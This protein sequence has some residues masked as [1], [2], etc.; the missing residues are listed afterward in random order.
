MVADTSGHRSSTVDLSRVKPGCEV[1]QNPGPSVTFVTRLRSTEGA[2]PPSSERNPLALQGWIPVQTTFPRAILLVAVL[3]LC[4]EQ[5]AVAEGYQEG[6]EEPQNSW[7]FDR[8]R[9]RAKL[10]RQERT[11]E[12]VRTG[13][14]SEGVMLQTF[15][16]DG[17]AVLFHP[18]PPSSRFDELK[19]A[20]WLWSDNPGVSVSV[21]IRLPNQKNPQ[22]GQTV[23]M[24]VY[25]DTHQ[26][27]GQWQRLEVGLSDRI[28]ADN[29]RRKR[30]EL[31]RLTGTGA[32]NTDDAYVDQITLHFPGRPVTWGL[33]IDDLEINQVVP[34]KA[35]TAQEDRDKPQRRI[36]ISDERILLDGPP[37]FPLFVPWH[38]ESTETLKRS[39]CN[40]VWVPDLNDQKLLNELRSAELGV[41]ATPPR[42]DLEKDSL[43]SAGLLPFTAQT[44]SVLFWMLDM[45]IPESRLAEATAWAEMVRDA[46]RDRA[47]PILAD[48]AGLE[49]QFHRQLDM[50]GATRSIPFTSKTPQIYSKSLEQRRNSALPGRP[51]FTLIPVAP[52]PELVSTRPAGRITPYIEPELIW[53]QA[54]IALA[55][56][57]KG[58]GYLTYDSLESTELG[59]EERRLAI[60]LM[61]HKIRLLEPWLA[62]AKVKQ[63]AR[64]L[65]GNQVAERQSKA[66]QFL[67][68]WDVRPGEPDLSREGLAAQQIQATVLE[69]DQGVLIFANWLEDSGQYQPGWM[70]TNDVRILLPS[71]VVHATELKLTGLRDHT[72]DA[73]P[74]PSGTEIRLKQGFNQSTILLV[75]NDLDAKRSLTERINLVRHFASEAWAKLARAKLTRVQAVHYELLKVAPGVANSERI[76]REAGTLTDRAEKAHADERYSEAEDLAQKA[77]AHLR[78]LQFNHW[79]NA[80]KAE[81]SPASSPYTVCFQT[82]PDHWAM[83][84]RIG[85]KPNESENLLPSGSFEDGDTVVAAG[86][87]HTTDLPEGS[88]IQTAAAVD[89]QPG[90]MSLH[91]RAEEPKT[92]YPL[93][94]IDGS[95]VTIASPPI[96]VSTGQI[97]RIRGRVQIPR[98]LS[99]TMDGLLIY[100]SLVGSAGALRFAGPTTTGKWQDFEYFREVPASCEMQIIL[101]LQGL[102]EALVDDLSVTAIQPVE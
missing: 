46:D 53:M 34:P 11:N 80:V 67:S 95:P 61:N 77:L 18:L 99:A 88:K 72:V 42:P 71:D 5:A 6:F 1:S 50:I 75:S 35:V 40:V 84:Q 92:K 54:D 85:K 29:L 41:M 4:M 56:G 2:K 15:P 10:L 83:K 51:M 28:F 48:V 76:L 93:Q 96:S 45:R 20:V 52:A 17:E 44:D 13:Q 69:C 31:S 62:T 14:R 19:V 82:L 30:S 21:R 89:G 24:D 58:I 55:A 16:T 81:N 36:R 68:R 78:F 27:G 74:V 22:T 101:E 43:D 64:V 49:R 87:Q 98:R 70:S 90:E 97:L 57:Y 37:F 65:V 12:L 3:C 63:Q 8:V 86:W 73:T 59:A 32:L 66:G 26:G 25:G 100:D 39:L 102:G 9:S 60:E 91:L 47:R 7:Q 38:G 94:S 23:A 79:W 33:A